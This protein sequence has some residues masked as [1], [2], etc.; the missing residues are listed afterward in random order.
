MGAGVEVA[1]GIAVG[2]ATGVG[3]YVGTGVSVGAGTSVG[4]DPGKGAE[5]TLQAASTPARS[6]KAKA[7]CLIGF[8]VRSYGPVL[9]FCKEKG[10]PVL[11]APALLS[12]SLTRN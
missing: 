6:N 10:G 9:S 12:L 7:R 8:S 2:V 5:P 1:A 11:A 3:V 4:L